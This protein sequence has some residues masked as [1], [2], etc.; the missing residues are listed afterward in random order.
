MEKFIDLGYDWYGAPWP[1]LGDSVGNGGLSLRKIDKMIEVCD[2]HKNEIKN[3]NEDVWFCLHT[4][5]NKCDLKTACNF[6]LELISEKYLSLIDE[7]PFGLHGHS[8]FSY[9]L[10]T[11][12]PRVNYPP[13]RNLAKIYY[14]YE[15]YFR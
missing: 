7:M 13:H 4:D 15:S 11:W 14:S 9:W 2:V 8:M 1:H 12:K 10:D 3:M 6:S 5:I